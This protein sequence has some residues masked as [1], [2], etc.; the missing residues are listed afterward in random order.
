MVLKPLRLDIFIISNQK[1]NLRVE[2][3]QDF[4]CNLR[5]AC[6]HLNFRGVQCGGPQK[7]VSDHISIENTNHTKG[8]LLSL[9][10]VRLYDCY[11]NSPF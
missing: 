2:S 1:T 6:R 5:A 10:K 8:T 4:A 9:L 7:Q 3:K 11:T